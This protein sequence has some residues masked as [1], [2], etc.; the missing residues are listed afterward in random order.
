[1]G[2]P[3]GLRPG[4]CGPRGVM[5]Q[6]VYSGRTHWYGPPRRGRNG[7]F[8]VL[9]QRLNSNPPGARAR[10]MKILTGN[11]NRP[12]AEAISA[13]AGAAAGQGADQAVLGQ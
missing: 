5:L 1:M 3:N 10:S 13:K 12:L 6:A 7:R 11:S 4:S 2:L 8:V 9:S